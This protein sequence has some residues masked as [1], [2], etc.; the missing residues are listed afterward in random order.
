MPANS[1]ISPISLSELLERVGPDVLRV[2]CA[3]RGLDRPA[4]EPELLDLVDPT[5]TGASALLL[6]VGLR[7]DNAQTIEAVDLAARHDAAALVVKRPEHR[8][9]RDGSVERLRALAEPSGVTILEAGAGVSWRRIEALCRAAS[10]AADSARGQEATEATGLPRFSGGDLFSLANAVAGIVGG[11]VAI[12]D[13]DEV[14]VAYSTLDG[15]LIDD[16][17]QRGILGRRVPEDA[18]PAYTSPSLWRSGSVVRVKRSGDLDRL[19]VVIR[20]GTDVLGSLWTTIADDADTTE[21]D[22]TLNDAARLAA[23]HMLRLRRHTDDEQERRNRTLRAALEGQPDVDSADQPGS[24]LL[25]LATTRSGESTRDRLLGLQLQDLVTLSATTFGLAVAAAL[26]DDRLHVL[27]SVS[28]SGRR[29]ASLFADHVLRRAANAL[30]TEL[31]VVLGSENTRAEDIRRHRAENEWAITH[32]RRVKAD[33]GVV[34]IETLRA[35]LTLDRI[36]DLVGRQPELR[37]GLAERI[38]AHDADK[39]T[40]YAETLLTYLRAF[41][42]IAT[43]STALHVHQN[44][45]RHRLHRAQELFSVDLKR[46]EHL[47]LLWL[48]LAAL[49]HTR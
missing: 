30:R 15:Q 2:V 26:L 4:G 27:I 36:T 18:L 8:E 20:A 6:G 37:S 43:A 40:D 5:P 33:A 44:T 7:V 11:A 1:L 31:F 29:Q 34:D 42:D 35:E 21:F 49:P 16:T 48:E 17:R 38:A 3:P 13:T 14:I 10:A 22:A 47:L 45:L 19:A 39:D 25:T 23:L 24:L 12:M 41:G 9:D 46:P 28:E 32:L